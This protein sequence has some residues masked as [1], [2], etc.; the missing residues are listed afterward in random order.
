MK[1]IKTIEEMLL[2]EVINKQDKELNKHLHPE[3]YTDKDS[4]LKYARKRKFDK[5]VEWLI[6]NE[7]Q[8]RKQLY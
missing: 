2:T 1:H 6:N 8:Y 3:M 5:G 7:V 4:F